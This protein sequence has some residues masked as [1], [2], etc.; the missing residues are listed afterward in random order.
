MISLRVGKGGGEI[1]A[2]SW[3]LVPLSEER[4]GERGLINV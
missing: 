2:R 4:V 1:C 3:C